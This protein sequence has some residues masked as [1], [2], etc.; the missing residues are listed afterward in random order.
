MTTTDE[1][2]IGREVD[3]HQFERLTE[4]VARQGRQLS[5]L[6]ALVDSQQRLLHGL[7]GGRM[8]ALTNRVDD[9]ERVE[10]DHTQ[11]QARLRDSLQTLG[12]T[13]GWL[14]QQRG[15]SEEPSEAPSLEEVRAFFVRLRALFPPQDTAGLRP[16]YDSAK[17]WLPD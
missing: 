16:P 8:G 7:A 15:V 6:A 2:E 3:K 1:N 11:E 13:V 5:E 12:R 4:T 9:L 17:V 14:V 10:R